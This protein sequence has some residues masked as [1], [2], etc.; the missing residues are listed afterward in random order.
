MT[1]SVLYSEK[2]WPAWWLWVA[3]VAI[4]GATLSTAIFPID[5]IWGVVTL[6][7]GI[8][9][10]VFILVG[11][12]PK[13]E[14][15]E[16]WLKVGRARIEREHVGRV[17]AHREDA[18]REQLGPGFDARS[19]QCIRGW[20]NP[21]VT[22]EITDPRDPKPYWLFSTRHPEEILKALG[23]DEPVRTEGISVK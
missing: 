4:G 20:I 11:T 21:V 13:I 16:K 5:V 14:V 9:L 18:A 22:A 3:V 23:A 15:T 1:D 12:T 2:L 10:G 7:G 6:L 8:A 19:Y 17:V